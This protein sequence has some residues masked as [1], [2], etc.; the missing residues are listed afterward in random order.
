LLKRLVDAVFRRHKTK[1]SKLPQANGARVKEN[2]RIFYC[3][4]LLLVAI[5]LGLWQFLWIY[6]FSTDDLCPLSSHSTLIDELDIRNCNLQQLSSEICNFTKLRTLH[7]EGN[8]LRG[9]P[10]CFHKLSHLKYLFLASNEFTSV[11]LVLSGMRVLTIL[12]LRNNSITEVSTKALPKYLRALILTKNELQSLPSDL[13][14]KVPHLQKLMLSH[15]DLTTVDLHFCDNLEL[16]RIAGNRLDLSGEVATL[17][18]LPRLAWVAL[19]GNEQNKLPRAVKEVEMDEF[20]LESRLGEGSSGIAWSAGWGEKHV[21][22]KLFKGENRCHVG[23]RERFA[24]CASDGTPESEIK[25]SAFIGKRCEFLTKTLAVLR[26]P[27]HSG[28]VFE[29]MSPDMENHLLGGSPSLA[30][31]TRDIYPNRTMDAKVVA[32]ILLDVAKAMQFLHSNNIAHG[33][34]YAHNIY[35]SEKGHAIVGDFG[36][37]FKYNPDVASFE[38]VEIKAF[39]ILMSELLSQV[40]EEQ[41]NIVHPLAKIRTKTQQKQIMLGFRPTFDDIVDQLEGFVRSWE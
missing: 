28:L 34:L 33:D 8:H 36:A 26:A 29:A 11:P 35:Y 14:I 38:A 4:C 25:I 30:T 21:V 1:Y 39:G 27:L 37:S 23:Q 17:S 31:I 19:G 9:L 7:L 32:G 24:L 12:D 6:Y 20:V 40:P 13:C 22:L 2:P 15:N 41:A 3:K 18:R 16:V 10:D 5:S